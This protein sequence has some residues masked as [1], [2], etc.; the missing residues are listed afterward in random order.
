[1]F[2]RLFAVL[3]LALLVVANGHLEA[4]DQCTDGSLYCCN[5][6]TNAS[7]QSSLLAKYGITVDVAAALGSVGVTCS[8]IGIANTG[9]ACTQQTACCTKDQFN[10]AV[11]LGCSNIKV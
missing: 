7:Q 10:G 6:V 1:M 5:Q 3:P 8:P 2:S 9:S 11:N 4:R